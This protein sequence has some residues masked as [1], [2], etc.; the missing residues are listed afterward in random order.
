[1]QFRKSIA[2]KIIINHCC[3]AKIRPKALE[4]IYKI[5]I[6]IE[7]FQNRFYL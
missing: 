4:H 3:P 2:N 1:M 5:R 7:I 6:R